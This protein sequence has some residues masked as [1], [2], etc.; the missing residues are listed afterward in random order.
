MWDIWSGVWSYWNYE[1]NWVLWSDKTKIELFGH[2]RCWHVWR[3]NR[4]EYNENHLIPIVKYGGG[5]LM[6]WGRFV[7][8][9]PGALKINGIM[10]S[11]KYHFSQKPGC[12]GQEDEIWL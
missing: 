11:T 2:V 9:G 7:A 3:Q 8:G 12:L 1:W 5:S 6:L 4:D 10:N